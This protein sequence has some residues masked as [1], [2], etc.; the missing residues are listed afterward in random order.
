MPTA[1][2][3]HI[4]TNQRLAP[5]RPAAGRHRNTPTVLRLENGHFDFLLSAANVRESE[6]KSTFNKLK[7]VAVHFSWL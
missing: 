4:K 5:T 7:H 1:K 3:K 6:D 2:T